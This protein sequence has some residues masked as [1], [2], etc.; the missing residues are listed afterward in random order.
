MRA[1]LG[2]GRDLAGSEKICTRVEFVWFFWDA[3]TPGDFWG[4]E[5]CMSGSLVY[6]GISS[7]Y[8]FWEASLSRD[9]V[10]SSLCVT[11]LLIG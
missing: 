9:G 1:D 4:K 5:G 8:L 11:G 2:K 3:I 7:Y 6:S 10:A